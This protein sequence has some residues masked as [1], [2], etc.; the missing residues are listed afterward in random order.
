MIKII[1]NAKIYAPEF[2]GKKDIVLAGGKIL[3]IGENL[4]PNCCFPIETEVLDG[5]GKLLL[6]GF[7]DNHVHIL[8][9]GGEGGYKT[10]TPEISLTDLTKGGI[11]TVVGCL[12]TDGTARSMMSLLAKAKGLREEGI[13]AFI[14]S[15]SYRVPITTITGD[16][17]TDIMSIEEIIGIGEIAVSD[18]RSSQPSLEELKRLAADARLGGILSGKAG[19]VNL[20]V[21]DGLRMIDFLFEMIEKTEIPASQFLPTHMNRNP[22]LFKEAIRY[23]KSG[24]Y[25]DFTTSSDPVFWEEGEVKTSKALKTCL[26]EGVPAGN[27][28]FSS[29]GQGSL[30]VFNEKRECIGLGVGKCTSLFDEVRDAVLKDGVPL[31]IALRVITS[32]PA[33]VLKLQEKGHIMAGYDADLVLVSED[34]LEIDTVIAKGQIMVHNKG[35]KVSDTFCR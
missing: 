30:P 19:V 31:E 24:G 21:G 11:T 12:G 29:D 25:I 9:G 5:Q 13:S 16:I 28:T 8:G 34:S 18:H 26:A 14:Y 17:P 10:R 4:S 20:H 2:I 33:A 22:Y 1:K 23:G 3:Y 15:G 7:I 6:P 32:N 27:I 35:I